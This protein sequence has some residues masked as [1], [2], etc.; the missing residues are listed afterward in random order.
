MGFNSPS[1]G[2]SS[3][4]S[5]QIKAFNYSFIATFHISLENALS[6]E[7]G[8][9]ISSSTSA[10]TYAYLG[11]GFPTFHL[12]GELTYVMRSKPII[13][14]WKRHLFFQFQGQD[15]DSGCEGLKVKDP[16]SKFDQD[17]LRQKQGV[18]KLAMLLCEKFDHFA[19]M[20]FDNFATM[21][22]E[23]EPLQCP[24]YGSNFKVSQEKV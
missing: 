14:E 6:I 10:A 8:S 22:E 1:F 7:V 16:T 21:L 18:I 24:S 15:W 13:F 19:T 5:L 9:L 20:L 2:T 23:D 4:V 12:R 17:K 3:H 11:F